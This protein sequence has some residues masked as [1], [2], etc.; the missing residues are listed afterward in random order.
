MRR[1][2]ERRYQSVQEFSD[3][4]RRYLDGLPVNATADSRSYRFRKF[5]QRN[6]TAV[7]ATSATAL[8]LL[9]ATAVTGWQYN[10][11]QRERQ[12]AEQRFNDTR[13]LAKSVLYE[14]YDAID[15]VPGSTKAKELLAAKAL[16]YLDR[17]AAEG[18]N[19]PYLLS[20][21]ADGY[22]RIGNIQGG[23]G[24][25]NLGQTAEAKVSYEKSFAIRKS[26]IDSGE[27]DPKFKTKLALAY[28]R[29]ADA[30]YLETDLQGYYENHTM[31]LGLMI[32]SAASTGEDADTIY[33]LA[34]AH[35]NAGRGACVV[36]KF[37]EG[38]PL[39]VKGVEIF[40]R[41]D[42]QYPENQQFRTGLIYSYDTL[43]EMHSAFGQKE[44]A[45]N[46]FRKAKAL[47][48]ETLQTLPNNVD[49][50]R[51]SAV[52]N[53]SIADAA[54]D[55]GRYDEAMTSADI[56]LQQARLLGANDEGNLDAEMLISLTIGN[57]GR[58]LARSGKWKE[59]IEALQTSRTTFAAVVESDPA[60][61]IAPFQLAGID[62]E[63]GRSYLDMALADLH[64]GGRRAALLKARP[65][66]QRA[67]EVYKKYRDDGITVAEDAALT[68]EVAALLAKC[69][70]AIALIR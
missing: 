27:T 58:V 42:K 26:I 65:L 51:F 25:A 15:A 44:E 24:Q 33:E 46:Q 57:R 41:L 60:N 30:D 5:V 61:K 70:E 52:V 39:L 48:D 47:V 35:I 21:L 12:M 3:D 62:D 4:I 19:D 38:I 54:C 66:L 9:T 37:D 11:A 31:A 67:Y 28:A 64:P 68:D 13:T 16:E 63:L 7:L 8:L 55:L 43:G 17:L 14:L 36:N 20:E 23:Y 32:D 22:Q 18:G 10:V 1:E 50:L 40:E 49:A 34:A 45:L 56:A 29:M 59:G 53:T 6:K 2:P 69:D